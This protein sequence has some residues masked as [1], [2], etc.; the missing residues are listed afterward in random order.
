MAP[1]Q[2]FQ[3]SVLETPSPAV[4]PTNLLRACS[5]NRMPGGRH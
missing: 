1:K 3:I 4:T 2:P 5:I